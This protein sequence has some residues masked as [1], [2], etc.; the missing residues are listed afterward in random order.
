VIAFGRGIRIC[1][2]CVADAAALVAAERA[3][4]RLAR[5]ISD[6]QAAQALRHHATSL[7]E[8]AETLERGHELLPPSPPARQPPAQQ[9]QQI[10]LGTEDEKE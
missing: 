4:L 6:E 9:Q 5:A 7:F 8:E 2:S 3:T 1:D 10:Q